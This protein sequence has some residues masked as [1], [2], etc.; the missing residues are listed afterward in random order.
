MA[1]FVSLTTNVGLSTTRT[2]PILVLLQ[3]VVCAR[4]IISDNAT[5]TPVYMVSDARMNHMASSVL[6]GYLKQRTANIC[7][8]KR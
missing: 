1:R 4:P 3:H 5:Q 7:V 6:S 2:A 8:A